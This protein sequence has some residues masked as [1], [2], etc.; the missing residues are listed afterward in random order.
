MLIETDVV[1]ANT[2]D[3]LVERLKIKTGLGYTTGKVTAAVYR[4][5]STDVFNAEINT[6]E[7]NELWQLRAEYADG[8]AARLEYMSA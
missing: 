1:T 2:V 5:R 7:H 8:V 4:H 3:E 6:A